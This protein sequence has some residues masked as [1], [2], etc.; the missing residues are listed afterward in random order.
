MKPGTRTGPAPRAEK[1]TRPRPKRM[2]PHSPWQKLVDERM[3]DLQITSRALASKIS[4]AARSFT[5][6]T[7]WAWTR[8]VDGAPPKATYSH[9]LN[10]RLALALDI[11]PETLAMAY[12]DSR[13]HLIITDSKATQ[14]GHIA[15]LR[16]LFADSTQKTWNKD[17]IVKLIDEVGSL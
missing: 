3:Q 15:I 2:D 17:E 11:P 13:R 12:E 10:R 5:H 16:R 7:V 8:C 9:D 4:T 14:R 1:T 6:T